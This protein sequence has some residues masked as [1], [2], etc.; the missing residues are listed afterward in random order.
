MTPGGF[1][2]GY[3]TLNA[4]LSVLVG[5]GCALSLTIGPSGVGFGEL[6]TVILGG[7]LDTASLILREIRLPRMILAVLVGATLGLSGA[8]MQGFLRNP[9]AEPGVIGV[10]AAAAFGAVVALYTGLSAVFAL[11][12]P[13]AAISGALLAVIVLQLLAGRQSTLTLI[14]AG[15]AISSLFGALT[16]LALNLSPNP[17]AAFEVMFWMLG[18]LT[19]RSLMHVQLAAPFI[20]AGWLILAFSARSLDALSLGEEA[21]ASLGV[22]ISR[23]RSLVVFGTALCVGAAVAVSGVIGFVGLVVPHL[24]RPLVGHKPSRLL[25]SSA[26]GG[27]AIVLFADILVRLITPGTELKLGVV[28]ALLGAPFFLYLVLYARTGRFE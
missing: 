22:N 11:A 12:L 2:I 13:V 7:D 6:W 14:L 20:L 23:S 15:V 1:S 26:L 4:G 16:S 5:F 10:S 21:A 25:L 3:I 18:S 28:T 8:A 17:F 19:D 9:L 24:L 27:A